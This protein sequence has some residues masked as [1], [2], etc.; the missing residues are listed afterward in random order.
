[1]EALPQFLAV[2]YS[3]YLA[4]KP[5]SLSLIED[6]CLDFVRGDNVSATLHRRS[7]LAEV[8]SKLS[9]GEMYYKQKV[10]MD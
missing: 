4:N 8:E 1:M 6:D 2:L 9:N 10:T 3:P 5:P 7:D